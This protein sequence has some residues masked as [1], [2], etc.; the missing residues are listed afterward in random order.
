MYSKGGVSTGKSAV[1][2]SSAMQGARG[3]CWVFHGY[4]PGGLA[5]A[6]T[7]SLYMEVLLMT[8]LIRLQKIRI[9]KNK[10]MLQL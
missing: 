8:D 10:N 6:I 9:Y 4:L 7:T 3:G 5:G 2:A 1:G